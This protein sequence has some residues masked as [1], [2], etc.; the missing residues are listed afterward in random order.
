MSISIIR[1]LEQARA[2][3]LK[4]VPFEDVQ[5][6]ARVAERLQSIFGSPISPSDAVRRI[7]HDVRQFGDKAVKGYT[8]QFDEILL[9]R[10][11]VSE[12][13]L[14]EGWQATSPTLRKSLQLAA[15]RIRTFHEGQ[16]V[17][18]W[19]K[20]GDADGLGQM[21]RPLN[22]VGIYVPGGSAAYPSSVL[23]SAVPARVAGVREVVI[24][25]PPD[26]Q[27]KIKP[28]VLAAARIANVDA[29]FKMGGA[30]AVAALA[31]GT[32]S[33]PRVDKIVGPGNLFVVLAKQQVYG[34]VGIDGL[35]G[36]TETVII[37]DASA[38]PH[39]IAADLI[40]QAEHDALATALLLT[41]SVQLALR[42]QVDVVKLL[43]DLP[44]Q[45]IA[46][47]SLS[48]RGA[49]V[50][51]E[52]IKQAIDLANEYAPEH[53][54]LAVADPVSWISRVQNAGGIFLGEMSSEGLG[55]YVVGPSHVMPT[56]GT[57]R[58]ASALNVLDFVKVISVFG[59]GSKDL[60][61]LSD[62]AAEIAEAE[63]LSGHAT[64]VR[65]RLTE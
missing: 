19:V 14:N 58:F 36:P 50:L 15:D 52:S 49:I 13:E 3:V 33:V 22:R 5:A 65:L 1:D 25:T 20:W 41:P 63:G 34:Q 62:A 44:R 16:Q 39:W 47:Q 38:H 43:S 10:L 4:R 60:H 35:P 27:G 28:A 56:G 37:A 8:K 30:Q 21:V 31:Y 54:C 40:A 2:T 48:N 26:V 32:A 51:T 12:E 17:K 57:A 24:A 53:L 59:V 64:A 61:L 6:P 11:R 29:V 55:D 18:S 45:D 9:P 7:L 46:V 42:V 23:M